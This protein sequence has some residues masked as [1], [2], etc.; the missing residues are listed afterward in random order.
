MDRAPAGHFP[1]VD[2]HQNRWN[3]GKEGGG[4]RGLGTN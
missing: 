3:E 4:G 2:R 1:C